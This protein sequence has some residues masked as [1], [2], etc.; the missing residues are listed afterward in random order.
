MFASM[1]NKKMDIPARPVRFYRVKPSRY[2]SFY[3]KRKHDIKS[4]H[5][6][7]PRIGSKGWGDLIIELKQ[8]VYEPVK[9][10]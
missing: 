8:P 3:N 5:V 9:K 2:E 7:P 10:G 6:A 4:V 1:R